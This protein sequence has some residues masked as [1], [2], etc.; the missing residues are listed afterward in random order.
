MILFCFIFMCFFSYFMLCQHLASCHK[1]NGISTLWVWK[2]FLVLLLSL[3]FA[4]GPH[5]AMLRA[6]GS[7]LRYYSWSW[8]RHH[9]MCPGIEPRSVFH[10]ASFLSTV[11]S[12]WPWDRIHFVFS[13]ASSI[14]FEFLKWES[15]NIETS[16]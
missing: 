6:L 15:M 3:L 9:S 5:P 4:F 2:L 8:L 11:L 14:F 16:P 1:E 7:M 10:K 12:C 13:I